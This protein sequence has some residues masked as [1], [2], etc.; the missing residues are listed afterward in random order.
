VKEI[1]LTQ[2]KFAKVDDADYEWLS[3]WKWHAKRGKRTWYSARTEGSGDQQR[4]IRM[5]RL[6]MGGSDLQVDHKNGD[7][8]NNQRKNLRLATNGQNQCNSRKN[9]RGSSIYKGVSWDKYRKR[10]R[11]T[12][13][14]LKVQEHLGYFDSEIEAA[15]AY[16]KAARELFR[17]FARLNFPDTQ[18]EPVVTTSQNVELVVN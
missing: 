7:G 14:Y 12:I 15:R 1:P 2:G 3:Q 5:H 13:V 16:D 17:E 9:R 18:P 11:A 8:L 4:T 10:W 6:I